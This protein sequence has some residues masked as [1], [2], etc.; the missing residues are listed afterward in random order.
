MMKRKVS[1]SDKLFILRLTAVLM[2]INIGVSLYQYGV[3]GM[4]LLVTI[5]VIAVLVPAVSMLLLPLFRKNG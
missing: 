1:K 5:L 2:G 3:D 4:R